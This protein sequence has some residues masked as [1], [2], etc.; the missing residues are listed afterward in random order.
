MC[1]CC[2]NAVDVYTEENSISAL[3]QV[4]YIDRQYT[5][6]LLLFQSGT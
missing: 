2:A 4:R 5:L 6:N 1:T 3:V